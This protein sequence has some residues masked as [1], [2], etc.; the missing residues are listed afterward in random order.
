MELRSSISRSSRETG[1]PDQ[2]QSSRQSSG[3]IDH[4]HQSIDESPRSPVSLMLFGCCSFAAAAA[5]VER[6]ERSGMLL[7]VLLMEARKNTID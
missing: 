3:S 4:P 1:N 6:I 2:R 7:H 5:D